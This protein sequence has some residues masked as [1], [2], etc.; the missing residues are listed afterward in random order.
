MAGLGAKIPQSPIHLTPEIYLFKRKIKP[1]VPRPYG[2]VG[3]L[4]S[5]A[6]FSARALGGCIELR[7][8]ETLVHKILNLNIIP[9]PL[10]QTLNV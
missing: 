2:L 5:N 7:N 1:H 10:T 9:K 6:L 3:L 8:P 4:G